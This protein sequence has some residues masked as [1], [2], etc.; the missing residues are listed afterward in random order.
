[1]GLVQQ[2]NQGLND[3]EGSQDPIDEPVGANLARLG[4]YFGS[5]SGQASKRLVA[6]LEWLD[7]FFEG[8][9]SEGAIVEWGVPFGLGGRELIAAWLA[10]YCYQ[11]RR[12]HQTIRPILWAYGRE[13]LIVNPPAWAARGV[14]LRAVRFAHAPS[15]IKQLKPVFLEPTFHLIFLDAPTVL[16]ADDCGF[17]VRQAR[18]HGQTIFLLRDYFLSEKKGNIW[19][20]VRVNCWH[21]HRLDSWR[22]KTVRGLSVKFIEVERTQLESSDRCSFAEEVL[23]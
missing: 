1:M 23:F 15:P 19:A 9:V 10:S 14:P 16:R 5:E 7:K 18:Q 20:K 11:E 22:L 17:L 3:Y 13:H 8:G 21:H 6:G 4:V 12:L 2:T